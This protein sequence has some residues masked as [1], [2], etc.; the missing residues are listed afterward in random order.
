MLFAAFL[1]ILEDI[2][3]KHLKKNLKLRV[4]HF[5]GTPYKILRGKNIEYSKGHG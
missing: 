2:D 3:T 5:L 4:R 1:V